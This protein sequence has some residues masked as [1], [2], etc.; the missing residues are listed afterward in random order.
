M[1]LASGHAIIIPIRKLS[2]YLA[3]LLF[4]YQ[5]VGMSWK[6]THDLSGKLKQCLAGG[7]QSDTGHVGYISLLN[8]TYTVD[9]GGHAASTDL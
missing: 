7:S 9:N 6:W 4:F 8:C 3:S 2:L 5:T 1:E